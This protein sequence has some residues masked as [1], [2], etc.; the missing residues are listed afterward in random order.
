MVINIAYA[1]NQNLPVIDTEVLPPMCVYL[2]R[3]VMHN[4]QNINDPEDEMEGRD[5]RELSKMLQ[6]FNRR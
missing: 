1:F 3:S 5:L 4:F 2:V 6:Y